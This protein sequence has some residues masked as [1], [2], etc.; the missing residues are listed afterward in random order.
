[1]EAEVV[2]MTAQLLGGDEETAQDYGL[3]GVAC[4]QSTF[5]PTINCDTLT[6]NYIEP[7][8]L[9]ALDVGYKGVFADGKGSIDVNAYYNTYNNFIITDSYVTLDTF[10]NGNTPVA[11]LEA[12]FRPYYNAKSTAR[13]S[14]ITTSIEYTDN[15]WTFTGNY[16]SSFE[17]K[18]EDREFEGSLNTPT[19]RI[20]L[21][22]RKLLKNLSFSSHLRWQSEIDWQDAYSGPVPSYYTI[23]AQMGYRLPVAKTTFKLGINNLTKND[24]ITNY[25][26]ARIGRVVYFAIT[27]D[28]LFGKR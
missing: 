11:P 4:K 1:M 19:H 22:V 23:D 28:E 24:Y 10:F 5:V 2:A 3:H 18:K 20:N 26:G 25:G 9:T 16:S 14:G 7:E 15:D 6:S 13:T 21:G 27:Y 8:R 12:I 17:L